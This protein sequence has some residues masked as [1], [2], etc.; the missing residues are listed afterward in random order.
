[1]TC[2]V[3]KL[4]RIRML[5]TASCDQTIKKWDIISGDYKQTLK[6]HNA[7]VTNIAV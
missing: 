3:T 1:M 2:H 7:S 4:N 5:F 6:G